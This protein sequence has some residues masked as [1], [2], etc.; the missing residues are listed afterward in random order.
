MDGRATP[1]LQHTSTIRVRY[2]ETDQM[3]VVYNGEYLTYFEVGRTEALRAFGL[4]YTELEK[5]GYLLPVI[6]ANIQYKSPAFYDDVLEI[7][8]CLSSYITA[9]ITISYII[10]RKEMLIAEGRTVHTFVHATTMK[11]ARP[12][13]SY[14]QM[15]DNYLMKSI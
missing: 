14:R 10:R 2:A 9:T 1:T 6:E 15:I 7:T 11:P 5:E 3:R 12:P 4:P 13:K 8:A